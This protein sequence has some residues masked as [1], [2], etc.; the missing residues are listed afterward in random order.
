MVFSG[1]DLYYNQGLGSFFSRVLPLRLA[2]DLTQWGSLLLVVSGLWFVWRKR[3][4]IIHSVFLFLP[5][6][7]LVEPLSWQHHY[8]FLLPVY[9]WVAWTLRKNIPGVV[10]LAFSYI[11]VGANIA[12]PFALRSLPGSA[13]LLSHV[14]FGNFILVS[15]VLGILNKR[16]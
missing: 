3:L 7:L 1:R 14:L 12:Y 9:V 2:G 8:V 10:L 4:S 15:L 11:L 16:K 5:I 13:L 6:F